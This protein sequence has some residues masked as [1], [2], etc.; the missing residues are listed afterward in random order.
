MSRF[1]GERSPDEILK[2]ASHWKHAA[3]LRGGSVFSS[4]SLWIDASFAELDEHFVRKPDLGGRDFYTKLQGQLTATSAVTK[5]LVAEIFW[6]IYLCPSSLSIDHK[7]S[8]ITRVWAW[9]GED[10]PQSNPWLRD[11][12]LMGVGSAGPGFNQNQW[13]EITFVVRVIQAFRK[14]PDSTQKDL[15]V[16]PWA[17]G[18]WI[19]SVEDARGRQFRHMLLFL[20]FPDDFERIFGQRDR[21]AIAAAFSG[22]NASYVNR[23]TP[24]E[25][26]HLLKE[27]RSTLEQEY[28]TRELDYYVSPLIERWERTSLAAVAS[29]I[30]AEHVR[31]ALAEID[32]DGV[33]PDAESARY[34]L[35]EG[36]KRYPPKYVLSL[37][38]KYATGEPLDRGLFSGGEDSSAF[39]VLRALGFVIE[40]K[41]AISELVQRFLAQSVTS[42]LSVQGYL[43]VYRGLQVKVSF[44]KGNRARIPWIAFLAQ[45]QAVSAGIYPVLL[46][47]RE[48]RK[49]LLCYGVSEE[50]E[51]AD[52]WQ[53]AP[54]K[55]TV[56]RWF[57]SHVGRAPERYGSSFVAAAYDTNKDVPLEDL[58]ADLD[59][60]IKEY[61]QL[62]SAVSSVTD[63][64]AVLP[65]EPEEVRPDIG[66]AASSFA[67]ALARAHVWFGRNHDEL[68]RALLVS[69][70][71][72][73]FAILTGL[74]GSGKTQI[75][76]RLGEWLGP[77]RLCVTAVRPDWTGAEAL[78][79]Y[80]DGLKPTASGRA[81]WNVPRPLQFILKAIH[82]PA[83]PY[84]LLL[85]EMNLAHVERYFAD[86]LSGMESDQSCIPNLL[87]DTDGCWRE[88]PNEQSRLQFPKNLWVVG[89]VNVDET[90]YM[91]S[92]KV[93]DRANVFEFRV[94]TSDLSSESRKP[95]PCETGEGP[96]LRGL[97]AIA[98]DDA[99]AR[100]APQEFRDSISERLRTL[101]GVLSRYGME[102]GHR[103][104]YESLKFAGLMH[105][106]GVTDWKKVLD[107]IVMQK[108]LPRLHG[109]RR[110]LELPLLALAHYCHVLPNE[111]P[112]DEKLM[113]QSGQAESDA[114]GPLLANASLKVERML[115]SLRINQFASFTE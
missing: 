28:G 25:L 57:A 74:S 71:A 19:G 20:L 23:L 115:V 93:L 91:F 96:L 18:D 112:A 49:L 1:C 32:R 98:I 8:V 14:M 77:E 58:T 10:L 110:R 26:D 12:V 68:T 11:E 22:R 106:A 87:R 16:K 72:K 5:R 39:R 60:V 2:A 114:P 9:S 42:E 50:G 81:A 3:L 56:E 43:E 97:Q 70:V 83:H 27:T 13:R 108:I 55:E 15:L 24:A 51:P 21:R 54:K 7:R 79:G 61:L 84:M 46:L 41:D 48:Q 69:L 4:Q 35:I 47:F 29:D 63:L 34:D 73:P 90:T 59:R 89:T 31:A 100:Q 80:E 67:T 30:K 82:D 109:S 88:K 52:H 44:G 111:M 40:P 103:T 17:F 92:P 104:F 95:V 78:F 102:F 99:Y 66:A 33:P 65:E 105:G 113:A 45:G 6:L 107:R 101:H 36:E 64:A 37:A 62:T 76:V 85:D 75:A 53:E 38:T 86:V 94:A